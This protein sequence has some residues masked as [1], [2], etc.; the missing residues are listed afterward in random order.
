MKVNFA[1]WRQ[2]VTVMPRI[3]DQEWRQLD[4]VSRW[5]ISTRFA[6]IFLTVIAVLVAGV[7]AFRSGVINFLMWLLMAVALVMAH[8]TNNILNDLIDYKKGIDRG[9]YFRDQYGP[10]PLERGFKTP[11]QQ[12]WY[13]AAN[14]LIAAACG[15]TLILY[16]GGLTL[17]LMGIGAFFVLFYTFPLKY[18]AL[19]EISL[20]IVYGPLVIGGGCYVLT[21]RWDWNV[22][23]ASLPFAL[24]VSATLFGKHI[25]KMEM[26]REAHVHTLPVVIGEVPARVT[27][28]AMIILQYLITAYLVIIG[29]FT[30]VMA[31]ILI[32][33]PDFFKTLLPMY[34]KP[35]PAERPEW[36]PASAWPLW[37]V[38]SAFRFTRRFGSW[39]VL[40]VVLDTAIRL[41][42]LNRPA[43]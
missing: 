9:N 34:R 42:F 37:Y 13:A 16:R 8:A 36:Y 20:I 14:G 12:F 21:G 5:L 39:Y 26:D 23:V 32:A 41:L 24:G 28:V 35:R 7:L 6:A 18:F 29:Y 17:P 38:G 10:Q 31:V 22:V 25:D 1:M 3:D 30:P 15:V 2:A 33:L 27:T 19:G 11:S 40:G 4:F 43:S